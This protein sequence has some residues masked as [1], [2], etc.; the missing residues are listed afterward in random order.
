[1]IM[2]LANLEPTVLLFCLLQENSSPWS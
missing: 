1:M 2:Y